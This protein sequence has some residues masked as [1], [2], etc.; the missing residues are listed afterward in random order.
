MDPESLS[1]VGAADVDAVGPV[2][3]AAEALVAEL[4]KVSRLASSVAILQSQPLMAQTTRAI[5][6]LAAETSDS[7]LHDTTFCPLDFHNPLCVALQASE[8]IASTRDDSV[9]LT[10]ELDLLITMIEHQTST[11]TERAR[12][13]WDRRAVALGACLPPCQDATCRDKLRKRSKALSNGVICVSLLTS[14][15]TT[16]QASPAACWGSSSSSAGCY[17]CAAIASEL[18]LSQPHLELRREVLRA[19]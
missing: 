17:G 12:S 10:Q 2:K 14:T 5:L 13:L 15:G 18:C 7:W 9:A 1:F 4:R 3:T 16:L 19:A 8:R 11:V 6:L